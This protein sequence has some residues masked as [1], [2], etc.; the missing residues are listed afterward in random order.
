MHLCAASC[1]LFMQDLT[2]LRLNSLTHSTTCTGWLSA[3]NAPLA[4]PTGSAAGPSAAWA[5]TIAFRLWGSVIGEAPS[6]YQLCWMWHGISRP[7]SRMCSNY[8]LL[9]VRQC[10][11]R[12]TK[13]LSALLNVAWDQQ[14]PQPHGQRLLPFACA[15]TLSSE[16]QQAVPNAFACGGRMSNFSTK[17]LL[18]QRLSLQGVHNMEQWFTLLHVVVG[19]VTLIACA[20]AMQCKREIWS[21]RS[22][23]RRYLLCC[24]WY[25]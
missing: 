4:D 14:A 16:Q 24:L 5:A 17:T 19:W 10:Y 22:T 13:L 6:C 12:S 20:C 21:A 11:G 9:P 23:S 3:A 25:A 1:S 7:F 2:N 8:C 18:E 15:A